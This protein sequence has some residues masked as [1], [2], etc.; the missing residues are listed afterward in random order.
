MIYIQLGLGIKLFWDSICCGFFLQIYHENLPL[1]VG[2][3]VP[4]PIWNEL[5]YLCKKNNPYYVRLSEKYLKSAKI[6]TSRNIV[7]TKSLCCARPSIDSKAEIFENEA[8]PTISLKNLQN[9]SNM[10]LYNLYGDTSLCKVVY[11]K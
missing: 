1:C 7:K 2:I 10:P 6:E 5:N 4:R 8:F 11:S 9:S 3:F